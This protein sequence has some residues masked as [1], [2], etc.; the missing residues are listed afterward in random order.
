M[1]S[2]IASGT[3]VSIQLLVRSQELSS[4]VVLLITRGGVQPAEAEDHLVALQPGQDKGSL[5]QQEQTQ[6]RRETA[7]L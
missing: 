3:K 7:K 5:Q 6:S 4:E 1:L 2:Q